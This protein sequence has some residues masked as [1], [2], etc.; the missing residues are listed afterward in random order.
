MLVSATPAGSRGR[1]GVKYAADIGGPDTRWRSFVVLVLILWRVNAGA[2]TV[3]VDSGFDV[4]IR[5][6]FPTAYDLR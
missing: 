3:D 1:T 6:G 4:S 5:L 2:D